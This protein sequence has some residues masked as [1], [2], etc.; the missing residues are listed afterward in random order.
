MYRNR[1]DFSEDVLRG[2]DAETTA[3]IKMSY[4]RLFTPKWIGKFARTF[5]LNERDTDALVTTLK[6]IPDSKA[7]KALGLSPHTVRTHRSK[8][9]A[10][11]GVTSAERAVLKFVLASGSCLNDR[12]REILA[13]RAQAEQRIDVED[14]GG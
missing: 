7:A 3:T 1:H 6:G 9:Y 4:A 13:S 12:D 5:R 2:P 11:I 8:M 10:K 14:D